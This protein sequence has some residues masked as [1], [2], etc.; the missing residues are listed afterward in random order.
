MQLRKS[1]VTEAFNL[2]ILFGIFFLDS[3]HQ[4]QLRKFEVTEVF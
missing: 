4:I 1:E 3:K 2:K